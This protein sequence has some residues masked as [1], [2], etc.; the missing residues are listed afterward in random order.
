MLNLVVA[1]KMLGVVIFPIL[2]SEIPANVI[3]S[4]LAEKVFVLFDFC[5]FC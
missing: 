4:L 5:Y 3:A 2:L 1:A